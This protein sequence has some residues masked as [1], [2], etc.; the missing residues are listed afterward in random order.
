MWK[1]VY[2]YKNQ[3]KL[4]KSGLC[5]LEMAAIYSQIASEI[6]SYVHKVQWGW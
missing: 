5:Y 1:I 4:Y 3:K 2:K 6:F